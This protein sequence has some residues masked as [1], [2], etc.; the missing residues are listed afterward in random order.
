VQI[1]PEKEE[2]PL[3]IFMHQLHLILTPAMH[4]KNQ[5]LVMLLIVVFTAQNDPSY[6]QKVS[7]SLDLD[8]RDSKI[9]YNRGTVPR[10]ELEATFKD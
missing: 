4:A 8:P 7:F 6:S 1:L 10:K 3:I 2:Y 5:A 9:K